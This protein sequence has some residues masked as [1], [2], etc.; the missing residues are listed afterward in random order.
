MMAYDNSS[1]SI[2]VWDWSIRVFHWC[3]PLLIFLMWLTQDQNKM[4]WHFLLG[5]ILL[6]LLVYRLIWGFIGTPYARFTHFLYGPK[7]FIAYITRLFSRD[8]PRY[9]SHNPM[10]GLM[11][12]VLMGAVIFQLVS[13]LF[14]TDDIFLSGPLYETVGRATSAWLTRWHRIFFDWLLILIGLHLAAIA[15]YKLRG[16]GL[17]KAMFTGKKD[18]SEKDQD[19]LVGDAMASFPWF[20][21]VFA[22]AIA[23]AV[24]YGVFHIPYR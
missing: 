10:G 12:L 22:V 6:G 11:V 16:E 23:A 21:F 18:A 19:P 24:V 1:Q 8:K 3:L 2:K 15:F 17:V 5:E 13:G 7:A 20:R 9:L 14:T 4:D